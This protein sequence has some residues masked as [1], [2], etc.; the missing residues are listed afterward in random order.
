VDPNLTAGNDIERALGILRSGKDRPEQVLIDRAG[1]DIPEAIE[2]LA[3]VSYLPVTAPPGAKI[4]RSQSLLAWL[5]TK[6]HGEMAAAWATWLM[7]RKRL[8]GAEFA[9]VL[10]PGS[11]SSPRKT[12][13]TLADQGV[14]DPSVRI[15]ERCRLFV[16]PEASSP[17]PITAFEASVCS[18]NLDQPST[19]QDVTRYQYLVVWVKDDL[20]HWWRGQGTLSV[21]LTETSPVSQETAVTARPVAV[22]IPNPSVQPEVLGERVPL[23]TPNEYYAVRVLLEAYPHR[24]TQ[25]HIYAEAEELSGGKVDIGDPAKTLRDLAK[26]HPNWK[27]VLQFPGKQHRNL[28]YGVYKFRDEVI[29]PQA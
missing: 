9:E 21:S 14:V 4:I 25:E 29:G 5:R 6:G 22:S 23:L 3:A 8:L 12:D 26:K 7:V 16:V 24:V 2:H 10:V 17:G 28:G 1:E 19:K 11:T 15:D 18:N 20:W 27:M 13:A